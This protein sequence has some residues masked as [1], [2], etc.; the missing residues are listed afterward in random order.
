MSLRGISFAVGIATASMVLVLAGCDSQTIG[1]VEGEVQYR[2]QP[3]DAGMITFH[4]PSTGA[5][6]TAPIKQGRFTFDAPL[7]VGKYSVY[8]SPPPPEPRDPRLG[9]PPKV[10]STIPK[11]SQDMITSGLSVTV[12]PGPN[13]VKVELL[14]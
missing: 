11:K 13:D 1:R 12:T 3:V 7:D 10:T 5:A 8:V 14:D 6:I 2:Q 4:S 9:P